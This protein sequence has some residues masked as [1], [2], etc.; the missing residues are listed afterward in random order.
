MFKVG[1]KYTILLLAMCLLVFGAQASHMMGGDITYRCLGNNV[2]EITITLYQDCLYGEPKAIDEDDP[3]N[4]SIFNSQGVLIDADSVDATSTA[5]VDPNFSNSCITN[6]PSTCM[7]RQVFTFNRTLPPGGPYYI[8]Y[9]RCCRN[10]SIN[11]IQNPGNVGVT[12]YATIPAFASGQCPNNSAVFNNF[13]PQ[14]IC[15]NNP[16]V[17]DFSATDIDGDSLSYQLCAAYPG[18]SPSEAKPYGAEMN[19]PGSVTVPYMPPY[20]A[21]YPMA[22]APPLQINAQTGIMTGTPTNTGRYIVT[23]CVSEWKNGV[24]VNTLSRDVQFVVTNC[25]KT[26]VANMPE[27]SYA[28]NTYAIECEGYT[29]HFTNLSTGGFSYRWDFGTG[30]GSTEFEPTYTFPDTGTYVVTLWVNEGSTCPDS[31]SRLVKIYPVFKAYFGW[32]G[33]LCPDEPIQFLDSSVATYPPV[34]SWQWDFGDGG[35]SS[36]QNPVHTFAKPGGTKAVQ[37]IA[38][39]TLG[40]R[41]SVTK[42]FPLAAFDP[43]AGNDT[44]VVLGYPFSLNGSGAQYY[45]WSPSD[46]LDNPNIAKP[47]TDFPD[48]GYYTYVLT[49]TSE[50]GCTGTD[51]VNIRVVAKEYIFVPN[52]FSPNG[53][54]LNDY[55]RPLIIG[56]SRISNFYI[57]NRFGQRVYESINLNYPSWN[58]TYNGRTCDVG[59]Y[60]YVIDAVSGK[61]GERVVQKGD[62]TL[63]R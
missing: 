54:G 4:F 5:I 49:G 11:N 27:L 17:Y 15:A 25:S 1:L 23:V 40:C 52:A 39:S 43:N 3:A 7:R 31:I 26:V 60:Y 62:I 28:P 2:F 21:T 32:S 45:Q 20:S 53:D 61:T 44:V 6:Y 63:L 30:A 29:V 16:F 12:Y 51:T 58:G 33:I 37:L 9:E 55:L 59:V 22:G 38:T 35:T 47:A 56:F 19:P 13:P 18:G 14:I 24:V 46:Y 34:I 36:S 10:A 50:E 8:V 42:Q 41:D 48:T 57:F